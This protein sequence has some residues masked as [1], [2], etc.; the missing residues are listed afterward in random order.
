MHLLLTTC[1]QVSGLSKVLHVDHAKC[2]MGTLCSEKCV[3]GF[4]TK[5]MGDMVAADVQA[6]AMNITVVTRAL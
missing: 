3:N 1:K 5:Q 6:V 2:I 4:Q